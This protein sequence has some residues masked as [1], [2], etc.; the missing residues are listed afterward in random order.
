M[1]AKEVVTFEIDDDGE[2]LNSQNEEEEE[3]E[4]PAPIP[5][6]LKQ[7]FAKKPQQQQAHFDQEPSL[8]RK[9]KD[10]KSINNAADSVNV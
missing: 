3:E 10:A 9:V 1:K 5:D 6:S 8:F 7:L 2:A 4:K